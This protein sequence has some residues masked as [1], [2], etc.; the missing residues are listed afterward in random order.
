[1]T[2]VKS[3]S[4]N[5]TSF[6]VTKG[7]RKNGAPITGI[8]EKL[9][10]VA[11]LQKKLGDGVDVIKWAEDYVKELTEKDKEGRREVIVKY[12]PV[13]QIDKDN[14]RQALMRVLS[15]WI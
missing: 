8:V 15:E 7:F 4:K 9:G 2:L 5:A 6:Y 3:E 1:M 12:S 14:Q 11:D 10:T 13:K